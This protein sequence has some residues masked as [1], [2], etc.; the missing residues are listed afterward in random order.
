LCLDTD[1]YRH[2][3][4]EEQFSHPQVSLYLESA[5]L[6]LAPCLIWS[7]ISGGWG[8]KSNSKGDPKCRDRRR[9]ESERRSGFI[10][11]VFIVG[12]LSSP[13]KPMDCSRVTNSI[14]L[15][16]TC[17]RVWTVTVG[18]SRQDSRV[19]GNPRATAGQANTVARSPMQIPLSWF[20]HYSIRHAQS[21]GVIGNDAN[22][23]PNDPSLSI[24]A[25]LA[26]GLAERPQVQLQSAGRTS[27]KEYFGLAND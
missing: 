6:N 25:L 17:P 18:V 20:N 1:Y 24:A 14:Q 7:L 26:A 22:S 10:S 11:G 21:F 8:C 19:H 16:K 13:A 15:R 23:M 4:S 2:S 27:Q 5:E 3:S 9:L 12:D